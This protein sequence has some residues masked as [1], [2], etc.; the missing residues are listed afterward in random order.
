M[1]KDASVKVPSASCAPIRD[2]REPI[3]GC[4]TYRCRMAWQ[5]WLTQA[6]CHYSV[7]HPEH[8]RCCN[9]DIFGQC[10]REE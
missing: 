7:K 2:F 3:V 4:L 6:D 1:A 5:R 9:Q 10:I 8:E